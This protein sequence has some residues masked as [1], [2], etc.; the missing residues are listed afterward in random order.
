M[1][2]W[3]F[4]AL[5][6]IGFFLTV[7]GTYLTYNSGEEAEKLKTPIIYGCVFIAIS[8]SIGCYHFYHKSQIL[9]S[10]HEGRNHVDRA[11]NLIFNLNNNPK[12]K[13]H[14]QQCISVLSEI[15][16]E[17]S[18]GLRKYHSPD[19]SVCIHY[20]NQDENGPY[21]NILC[22]NTESKN[23]QSKRPPAATDK[24][25]IDE[26]TDFKYLIPLLKAKHIDKIYY[27][28]N[29][30]PFSPWYKNSHFSIEMQR[31]YYGK[32][33]WI[34]RMFKWELPYRSTL[35]VPLITVSHNNNRHI[36]G[37]LSLDSP[38]VWSFSKSYDLPIV[39]HLA[40]VIAPIISIYNQRNLLNG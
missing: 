33:G 23:R 8:T 38:K 21:V 5:T 24:D 29:F 13:A 2:R 31:K 14:V 30:L 19:I 16:Q 1:K 34:F 4:D 27:R 11:L 28:N 26:N 32:N 40:N 15:C 36:E 18:A 7:L 6:I 9:S 39:L 35:V 3:I 20:V 25:Y 17:V 22:R 37:F 12:Q 10:V